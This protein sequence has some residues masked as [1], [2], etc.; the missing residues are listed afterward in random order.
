MISAECV[1]GVSLLVSLDVEATCGRRLRPS[2]EVS[3]N[4]RREE[5]LLLLRMVRACCA[6]LLY[7]S[8]VLSNCRSRDSGRIGFA[9]CRA[10]LF[11]IAPI[12]LSVAVWRQAATSLSSARDILGKLLALSSS[13]SSIR[14]LFLGIHVLILFLMCASGQFWSAMT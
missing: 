7:M 13:L 2:V 1:V 4:G 3:W 6:W 8:C 9:L 11:W 12:F 5:A 14:A 10:L